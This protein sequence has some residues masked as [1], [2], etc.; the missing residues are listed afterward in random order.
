[1]EDFA[2][3]RYKL[4]E[5]LGEGVHGVVIKAEDK[6]N[7]N[8]IVA[9]KKLLLKNKYG[10][11]QLSTLREI[12]VLQHC[13]CEYVSINLLVLIVFLTFYCIKPQIWVCFTNCDNFSFDNV[14]KTFI[15]CDCDK[16]C[17]QNSNGKRSNL[18]LLTVI[19]INSL[20]TSTCHG[21]CYTFVYDTH[22]V[23]SFHIIMIK[24][25]TLKLVQYWKSLSRSWIT[26]PEWTK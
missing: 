7:N 12:K 10:G 22:T 8:K 19:V 13:D 16:D 15:S 4:L 6:A 2:P 26:W 21:Y 18:I 25:Q 3:T 24:F 1:M 5:K 9:I 20:S 23:L 17:D 11:L 14:V